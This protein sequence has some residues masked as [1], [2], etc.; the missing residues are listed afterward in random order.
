[1]L[2]QCKATSKFY[3]WPQEDG[4][5]NKTK[6]CPG[7]SSQKYENGILVMDYFTCT[8]LK[9]ADKSWTNPSDDRLRNLFAKDWPPTAVKC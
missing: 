3:N 1:M 8:I 7:S 4:K 5:V 2:K 6:F 9:M